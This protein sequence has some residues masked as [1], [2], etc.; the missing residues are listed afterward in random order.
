[1]ARRTAPANATPAFFT[2]PARRQIVDPNESAFSR[3]IRE[4]ITAPEKLPGNISI[5]TGMSVFA[6]GIFVARTWGDML[7]PA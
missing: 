6:A 4:Q 1:M 2:A 5:V 3:F 7:V